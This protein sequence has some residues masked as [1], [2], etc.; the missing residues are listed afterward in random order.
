M[1][2]FVV[3]DSAHGGE[4]STTLALSIEHVK[5]NLWIQQG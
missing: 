2:Q 3:G 4:F 1:L 5:R